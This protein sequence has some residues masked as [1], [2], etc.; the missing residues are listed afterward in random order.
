M[1]I[2]RL[3]GGLGNQLFQYATGYSFSR[4]RNCSLKIDPNFYNN[5]KKRSFDLQYFDAPFQTASFSEC[6]RL[7]A[8]INFVNKAIRKAGMSKCV[9]P[10]YL[11][12]RASFTFDER[13]QR[14]SQPLY[15]D[16]YW[17]NLDY[18]S[19]FQDELRALFKPKSRLGMEFKHYFSL[20]N[21]S[22]S[23]AVHIRRGDY[24]DDEDIRSVHWVCGTDYYIEGINKISELVGDPTFFIFSDDIS[25]CKNNIQFDGKKVFVE[26]TSCALEDFLLIKECA[27][28]VLSNSTFGWWAAFLSENDRDGKIVFPKHWQAGLRFSEL[29]L[30]QGHEILI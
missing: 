7:G 17:Q 22:N 29:N 16:G 21:S 25:W 27:S 2:V 26:K 8:P 15:I 14:S 3:K 18:F 12:E 30:L 20:I 9:F 1:I 11:E 23:V 6:V 19:S 10:N 24:V 28:K 13:L 4:L 5:Q